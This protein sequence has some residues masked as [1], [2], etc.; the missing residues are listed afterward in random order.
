MRKQR[1][2]KLFITVIILLLFS[3]FAV[4]QKR[5]T[6]A[7]KPVWTNNTPPGT[8]LGI[9]DLMKS[10][11][12]AR[13]QAVKDAK[14]QIIESLGGVIESEFVDN[15]IESRGEE[16][17]SSSFTESKVKVVSK[18]IL[19]VKPKEVFTEKWKKSRGMFKSEIYYKTYVLVPF[20]REE[21]SKYM[22]AIISESCELGNDN[23][24]KALIY[25]RNQQFFRGLELLKE[26]RNNIKPMTEI[27]GLKASQ[28][29]RVMQVYR[30]TDD[31]FKA[32]TSSINVEKTNGDQKS[33]FG[34]PLQRDLETFVYWMENG[35]RYGIPN[36][37][38]KYH[39]LNGAAKISTTGKTNSEG[40]AKCK[41]AKV[42]SARDLCIKATIAFAEDLQLDTLTT[43]Y[44]IMADN[45]VF[46]QVVEK[47][48]GK[49][50]DV[51]HLQNAIKGELSQAG[52]RLVDNTSLII[53]SDTDLKKITPQ[54]LKTELELYDL[55][56]VILGKISANQSN[57]IQDGFHFAWA[58]GVVKLVDMRNMEVLG[59]YQCREKG[60][61]NSKLNA[62]TKSITKTG[63]Q[64]V[65]HLVKGLGIQN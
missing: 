18:N 30:K 60:A 62:G 39:I 16:S 25:C 58:D 42:L 64:L 43:I 44:N 24:E 3:Q 41:V 20:S 65:Q 45:K 8:F 34:R 11:Q 14:R 33:K 56:F 28:L 52:F 4:G 9:S 55:D 29:S 15:I 63:E 50:P 59:N 6:R 17:Y 23:Y 22:D 27:T 21:H 19:A 35:K 26:V 36:L 47:N 1:V 53:G 7:E 51:N 54:T 38:V 40:I 2:V 46:V 13:N 57:K 61:G 48:F 37:D 32:I 31:K 10:E 12:D 49:C 5:V